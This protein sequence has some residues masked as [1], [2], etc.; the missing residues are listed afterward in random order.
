M[1]YCTVFRPEIKKVSSMPFWLIKLM[2]AI[3]G[4]RALKGAGEMMSYFEKIGEGSNFPKGNDVLSAP[5]MTLDTWLQSR[6][7]SEK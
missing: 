3:T 2:G 7:T 6:K 4:N 5:T 1:R